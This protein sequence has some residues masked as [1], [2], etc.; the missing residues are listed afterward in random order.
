MNEYKNLV[1]SEGEEKKTHRFKGITPKK[2]KTKLKNQIFMAADIET[3]PIDG[4]HY[5]YAIGM[6]DDSYNYYQ[7]LQP[8]PAVEIQQSHHGKGDSIIEKFI[9]HIIR[10]LIKTNKDIYK[11]KGRIIVYFHNLNFDGIFILNELLNNKNLKNWFSKNFEKKY[12]LKITI[13]K[14]ESDLLSITIKVD[15]IHFNKKLNREIKKSITLI[16]FKDSFKILPDSLNKLAHTFLN[17]SKIDFDHTRVTKEWLKIQENLDTVK[18]YLY[19]DCRLLIDILKKSRNIFF[20]QCSVDILRNLTLPAVTLDIFRTY[21]LENAIAQANHALEDPSTLMLKPNNN[22]S[23]FIRESYTGGR[24]D[25]FKPAFYYNSSEKTRD[26]SIL[27]A[28]DINSLYPSVMRKS[29]PVGKAKYIRN[30]LSLNNDSLG[31]YR[32]IVTIDEGIFPTL[33]LRFKFGKEPRLI[34]PRGRFKGIW[35]SEELKLAQ[36]VGAKIKLIDGYVFESSFPVFMEFV[37]HFYQKRLD[38]KHNNDLVLNRIFKLILNSLYGRLGMRTDLPETFI[39]P[40]NLVDILTS[41]FTVESVNKFNNWTILSIVNQIPPGP[42][43]GDSFT[44]YN[45]LII[46]SILEE[47]KRKQDILGNN[48]AIHMAAAITSLARIE[49]HKVLFNHKEHIYYCDTDSVFIA[50]KLPE[51]IVSKDDI[52][53]WKHE[54][55]IKEAYFINPKTYGYIK[56]DDSVVIKSKGAL[57]SKIDYNFLVN[58]YNNTNNTADITKQVNIYFPFQ[59]DWKTLEVKNHDKNFIMRIYETR[60]RKPLF[61]SNGQWVDT[62]PIV[63]SYDDSKDINRLVES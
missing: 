26:G 14:R 61:D 43:H 21:F 7:F 62:S 48:T 56:T 60:K 30:N 46:E 11:S 63:I 13:K 33:P 47:L 18:T 57:L 49:L 25:V 19:N 38:A 17:Q 12:N 44:H 58:S 27:K 16:E 35:Y 2:K 42:L 39:V 36:S 41:Y 10:P 29:M 9:K 6:I 34:F 55:D 59:K 5:P 1:K 20:E 54:S 51:N 32:A 31:F 28:Y 3:L 23:I 37:D 53:K 40:N 15:Y 4:I 22:A 8:S 52:G 45:Q 24:V 50:D